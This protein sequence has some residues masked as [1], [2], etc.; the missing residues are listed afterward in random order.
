MR[1]RFA[2]PKG[3]TLAQIALSPQDL[4]EIDEASSKVTVQGA[5][6]PEHLQRLV[7]R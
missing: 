3:A 4:R 5:R 2:G 1:R 6:Y 7:G